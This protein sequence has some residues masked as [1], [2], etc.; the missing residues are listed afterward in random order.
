MRPG[1]PR[2]EQDGFPPKLAPFLVRQERRGMRVCRAER[3]NFCP[4]SAS[5]SAE[6]VIPTR[7]AALALGRYVGMAVTCAVFRWRPRAV[8]RDS[9]SAFTVARLTS[10]G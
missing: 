3:G 5:A 7:R 4:T 9:Y 1:C 6:V 2:R 8:V 10:D